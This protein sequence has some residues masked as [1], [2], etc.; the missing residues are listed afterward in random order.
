MTK[1]TP[2]LRIRGAADALDFYARAF[3]ASEEMRLVENPGGRIGHAQIRIGD[4]LVMLSDEYPELGILGPQ[5]LGGTSVGIAVEVDDVDAFMA[6]AEA[7]GAKVVREAQDEFYGARSGKLEDP[8]GHTWQ[9]STG[10]EDVTPEEMQRRYDA[11][12]SQ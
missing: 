8:F 1:I 5:S 10:I 7:A 11:L 4:A 3:G 12:M 2:Y 6:A 9:V